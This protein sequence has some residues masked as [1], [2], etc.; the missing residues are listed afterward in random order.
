MA[1]KI[2]T[3]PLLP[4]KYDWILGEPYKPGMDDNLRLL[5][6]VVQLSVKSRTANQ[7]ASPS[8]GD[9]YI[10]NGDVSWSVG[11]AGDVVARIA[12]AWY[13][14][15]PKKGWWTYVE[16]EQ[17]RYEYDG[18]WSEFAGGGGGGVSAQ[19]LAGH[20][21]GGEL[22]N[23]ATDP[24]HDIDFAPVVCTMR[25][26]AGNYTS[27][28][29]T[30]TITKRIDAAWAAGNNAGGL[31][32]AVTL[33]A[34]SMYI[35]FFIGK[36]DGTVDAGWDTDINAANLLSDA[37]GY[38]WFRRALRGQFTD[39]LSN[40]RGIVQFGDVVRYKDVVPDVDNDS[41]GTQGVFK[42]AAVSVPPN[43]MGSFLFLVS[44]ASSTF[45]SGHITGAVGNTSKDVADRAISIS[46]QTSGNVGCSVVTQVLVS[47]GSQVSYTLTT[48]GSWSRAD[49]GTRGWTDD[50][51]RNA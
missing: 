14:F 9:R 7:P 20:I 10:H 30:A 50:R 5:G 25:D 3:A 40:L 12:G 2:L 11:S 6:A 33:S 24:D 22:A 29:S 43:Q 48:P 27:F 44:A 39:S 17:K 26:G 13:A 8:N 36:D 47:A 45:V 18:G 15:T 38:S 35:P 16:D 41:T 49:V 34:D 42:T 31:A 4:L 46:T 19:F 1:A 37:T 23:N 51:G 32:S 28:R 21:D